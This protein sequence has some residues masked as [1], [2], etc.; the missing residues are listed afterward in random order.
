[1]PNLY[2]IGGANGAGKTTTAMRLLPV[3]LNCIEYVNADSIAAGLSPFN[4]E[5]VAIRAGRLM[6]ERI[7]ELAAAGMDF[8]FETTLATRTLARLIQECRGNNYT[9]TLLYFWLDNPD[10]AVDRVAV[11]VAAGGHAIPEATIRRRY[12][13]GRKNFRSL[14]LPLADACLVVD[15]SRDVPQLVAEKVPGSQLR[16]LRNETWQSILRE[17]TLMYHIVNGKHG[18]VDTATI[19]ACIRSAVAEAIE[20]HRKAGRS[21]VIWRDGKIVSIPPEKIR[22]LNERE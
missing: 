15:N 13:S 10:L 19:M 1:M 18:P 9:V 22:P 2:V 7:Y 3:A 21:I 16:I 12:E 14:F 5:S 6:I 20:E 17:P 8:A 11:R 4:P